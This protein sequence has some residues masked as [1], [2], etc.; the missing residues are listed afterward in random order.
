VPRSDGTLATD[1]TPDLTLGNLVGRI[2][3]RMRREIERTLGLGGPNLDQWRALDLLA[4]GGGHS[5]TEIAGHVMVPAPTLTKIVDR[6]VESALVYRYPDE[7]DRRRILVFLSERGRELH[8]RLAP[9]VEQTER[10]LA[11]R[12]GPEAAQ[13]LRLLNRLAT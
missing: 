5:M 7:C 3:H 10:E 11:D 9:E 12:L 4:D 13:L 8:R 1:A 6:L 2:E